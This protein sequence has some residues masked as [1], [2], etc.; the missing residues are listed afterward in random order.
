[1]N[2]TTAQMSLAI[3]D[4]R[5]LPRSLCFTSAHDLY[6]P[7]SDDSADESN[8]QSYKQSYDKTANKSVDESA[9][10]SVD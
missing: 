9:G 4:Y 5:R 2:S 6:E 3:S 1:M 8:D 7:S 10:E